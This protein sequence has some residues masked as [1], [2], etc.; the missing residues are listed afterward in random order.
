MGG[1]TE[2]G[3]SDFKGNEKSVYAVH[4]NNVVLFVKMGGQKGMTVFFIRENIA[5]YGR[6]L[7]LFSS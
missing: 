6:P 5:N 2:T 1:F 7:R 3:C 4:S